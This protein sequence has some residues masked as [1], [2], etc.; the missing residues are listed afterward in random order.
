[1]TAAM[2]DHTVLEAKMIE[3]SDASA[4]LKAVNKQ[5]L[6]RL[7]SK[8]IATRLIDRPLISGNSSVPVTNVYSRNMIAT[9]IWN[10]KLNANG[11]L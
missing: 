4:F 3:T 1:M 7:Y 8:V 11:S 2:T 10:T 5:I 6:P 9:V